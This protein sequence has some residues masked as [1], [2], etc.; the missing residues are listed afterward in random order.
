MWEELKAQAIHPISAESLVV[1]ASSE[2]MSDY[3]K[4]TQ[5]AYEERGDPHRMWSTAYRT[6][7]SL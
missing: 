7:H 5:D 4:E 6:N 2:K 3:E 1:F